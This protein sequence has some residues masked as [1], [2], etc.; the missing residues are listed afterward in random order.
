MDHAYDVG[1]QVMCNKM[2]SHQVNLGYNS[3]EWR[4]DIQATMTQ[5]NHEIWTN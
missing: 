3:T 5:E 2:A 1:T 4:S